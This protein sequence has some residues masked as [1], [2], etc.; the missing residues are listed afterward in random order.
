MAFFDV[1][2][3]KDHGG[4]RMFLMPASGWLPLVVSTVVSSLFVGGMIRM[5]NIQL[6]GREP[7]IEDLFSVTDVWFDLILVGLLNGAATGLGF[8]LCLVP[9]FIVSG[10]FMLAIPL[11]VE[12]R[13]PATGAYS[14]LECAQVAMARRDPVSCRGD[15]RRVVR[16][17][18]LRRRGVVH[19]A[20][21]TA[22][23]ISI[24]YRDFYAVVGPGLVEEAPR[25]VP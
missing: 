1:R 7:R 5:A 11:V 24:L 15:P 25:A 12:G 17:H 22:L 21:S 16:L 19:R 23:A 10:L 2:G 18:A 20:R 9:G 14:E 8:M 3:M 4:F 13:L 6:Q